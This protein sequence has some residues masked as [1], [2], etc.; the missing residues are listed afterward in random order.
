M[1]KINLKSLFVKNWIHLLAIGLFLI[2]TFIYFQPQF[3]GHRLKQHDIEQ[4][5]GMSNEIVHY[6]EMTGEEPLWTNSMFGGMPAYQISVDYKGNILDEVV[7]FLNFGMN[8]PA[9]LFI[10]YLLGFYIMLL[11][12]RINPKVAIFGAFAFAFSSYYIIILQ[13]GHNSKAEAIA[14]MAPVIGAF[15]MAYRYNLKW[16][17]LLSALFMGLHLTSNHFQITFYLG[18]LLFGIGVTEFIRAVTKNNWKPFIKATAGILLAYAFA[19]GINYGNISLTNEYAKY[20]I[21]GGNDITINE[22]GTSAQTNTTSGLDKDYIT[23]WS[24]GVGESMTLLSPYVKGGANG[25]LQSS[26]FSDILRD[27]DLRRNASLV[28]KNDVYW[29]AQ[30]FVSG[31]VYLGIIVFFLALM[32]MVYLKGPLKWGLALTAVLALMLSWGKNFMGLTDFFIEYIPGYNKFRAVTIILALVELIIP[33]LGV[34]FLNKLFQEREKIK[35]NIRPFYIASGGLLVTMIILTFTGLG[36]GYLS[37]REQEF[38]YNYEDQVR[39]QIMNE[40]PERLRQNGIDINNPQQVKQL[41]QQQTDRVDEQFDTLIQVRQKIYTSSMMRSILFLILGIGVVLAFIY[42]KLAKEVIIIGLTAIVMIDLIIVDVNYLNN[43]KKGRL[44]YVHWLE[45][46]D[47]NYPLS[48]T[49]ADKEIF[50]QEVES[51]QD[52]K[53]KVEEASN[54]VKKGEGRRSRINQDELWLKKFQILNMNSNYRVYEPRGG[55][56]SSRASYFHK[57]INGYHGAKL[58]RIQ[59]VM[60]FHISEGNMD[61]LN[62]L[63]VKYFIQQNSARSNPEALGNAWMIR[64]VNVQPNPNKEL[65]ALGNLYYI[66]NESSAKLIINNQVKK[67]DTVSGRETVVLFDNDSLDIDLSNV[68]RSGL[69]VTYVQD[70]NGQRN[71]IPEMQLSKDT[72]NSFKR[73]LSV[74]KIHDFSPK[75]EVIVGQETAQELESLTYSGQGSVEMTSYAP[76]ELKYDVEAEGNQ[77]IV[78]SEVYYPQGW[79]AF[80]DDKEVPI[81]RVNYM[82]RGLEVSGGDHK[83]VMKFEEPKFE[84]SNTIAFIGSLVILLLLAGFFV[85]DFILGR[86]SEEK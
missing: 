72:T 84:R 38:I 80:V 42:L 77:F 18:I 31:P 2:V 56:N 55:F 30:P 81:H 43:E 74:R 34:L 40:D 1:S 23:Q 21:R 79:K 51:N 48:P 19:L 11:C 7:R 22:D 69:D 6:R 36:D 47:F 63:N 29:G 27:K 10:L 17:V 52:L 62:M 49:K 24:Y 33:L 41:V 4:F 37:P 26:Q 32:G 67:K 16:G 44:G 65:L 71:W 68:K 9:G 70:V 53:A 13:A 15:Y 73:L 76:N 66:E 28:A 57:A 5:K 64:N 86:K 20:T 3:T 58:R 61:V 46:A 35:Q 54:M 82:L 59:N 25:E 14:L 39:Q 83:I 60:N 12:M 75:D 78:F 8:S 50:N 45:D 85:K